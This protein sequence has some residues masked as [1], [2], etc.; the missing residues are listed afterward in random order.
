MSYLNESA[1]IATK[2]QLNQRVCDLAAQISEDYAGK[3]LD[4]VC[5]INSSSVF[6]AD[7][8]RHL[9]INTRLHFFGFSSYSNA[10][11]SG[12]VRVTLDVNEPLYDRHV[13]VVEGIVV[14]GR[15]PRYVMD[16]MA[17]RQPASLVMCALGVKAAQLS[18]SLPLK[19]IGFELGSE[20][21]VGYGVGAA[22][23]KVL[24]SLVVK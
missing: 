2:E 12:E 16:A 5:L 24:S 9:T 23:E 14:S 22:D 4:V 17:L 6:C 11:P 13:L 19:Y 1:I 20:I 15:T 21:A 8:V 3:T 18:V 10:N 7:L